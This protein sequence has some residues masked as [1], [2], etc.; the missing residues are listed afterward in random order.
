VN[1]GVRAAGSEDLR[2]LLSDPKAKTLEHA[3]VD[4]TS[5]TRYDIVVDCRRMG[6]GNGKDQLVNVGNYLRKIR[7]YVR[8]GLARQLLKKASV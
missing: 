1:A 7:D 8:Q 3:L 4:P 6:V 5:G 2:I